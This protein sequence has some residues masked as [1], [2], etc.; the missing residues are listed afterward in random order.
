MGQR[1][2]PGR[3]RVGAIAAVAG[4]AATGLTGCSSSLS[5]A[6]TVLA[7]VSRATVVHSDGT[8][9]AAVDGLRLHAGD[10]VRTAPAGRAELVTRSRHVYLGSVAAVRIV[11]GEH[12][13]LRHGAMV[14]DAQHGSALELEVGG[15]QVMAPAGSALRAERSATVRLGALAGTSRITSSTGRSLAVT[16]LHQVVVGGDAL[17]DATTPLRLTDDDGE[18]RA[19]PALVHDDQSLN[20]LARGIDT[21]GAAAAAVVTAA[22]HGPSPVAPA[23]VARSELVLPVVIAAAGPAADATERLHAAAALRK[24][25]GSWGVVAHLLGVAAARVVDELA[26][27]QRTQAPG[28][29][30]NVREVLA[31]IARADVGRGAGSGGRPGSGGA[32]GGAAGGGGGG[33]VSGGGTDGGGGAGGPS[34]SPT[35]G[36]VDQIV[37][38]VDDTVGQVLSVVPTPTST[39]TGLLPSGLTSALPLPLPLP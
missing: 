31:A 34:P 16:A 32:G 35:P 38:T 33:D 3:A 30:G 13:Q 39:P 27:L 6:T 4:L 22:W 12:Q 18:A 14:V 25:G 19:V 21:S 8:T 23:G 2:H 26:V 29:L 36:A 5:S 1:A 15:L 20:G 9:I 10:V 37:G 7:G 28:S 17:P 24:A 11:D